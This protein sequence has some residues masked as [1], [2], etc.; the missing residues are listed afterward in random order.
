M[1]S[2]KITV[3]LSIIAGLAS[4]LQAGAGLFWQTGGRPF[5]FT[6]LHGHTIEM[7]GQGVYAYDTYFKAPIFR[8]S[9]A[10]VLFL[11]LP[12]LA[13][14]LVLYNRGSLR[15][16]L[17]LTGSLAYLLYN[18]ASVAL[19]IAYNNLFL[20]Y[21]IS[22]S[23]SL[24]AFILAFT[25][26]DF[27]E[28]AARAARSA[29]HKGITALMLVSAVGLIAACLPDVV[30]PLLQGTTPE[31]LASYT[32]EATYVFDLGI[33]VPL[34]IFAGLSVLK[35]APLGYLTAVTL[36]VVLV[37]IGIMVTIQTFFQSAA[38]INLPI[39]VFAAKAGSFIVLSLIAVF[40]IARLFKGLDEPSGA[41]K[42]RLSLTHAS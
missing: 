13:I 33:I 4:A 10:M 34:S 25:T 24:F 22:F 1:K 37:Q 7:Y 32:T 11:C 27:A 6:T 9:D 31:S 21:L 3:I 8:G 35:R 23:A 17:L 39:Q 19:G 41:R 12:F 18:N 14:A 28:L 30:V 38:G 29:P 16:H 15:G 20:V 40:L 36:L 2:S 42:K 5:E 26:V